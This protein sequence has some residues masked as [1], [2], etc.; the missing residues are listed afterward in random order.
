MLLEKICMASV[1]EACL[2][3][4]GSRPTQS[5]YKSSHGVHSSPKAGDELGQ[6]AVA[7]WVKSKTFSSGHA[8]A[9]PLT[10]IPLMGA[11][12]IFTEFQPCPGIDL[13]GIKTSN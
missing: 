9:E 8:D 5:G 1:E 3:L 6:A 4:H 2:F 7:G 11:I 12:I 13:Y 10:C